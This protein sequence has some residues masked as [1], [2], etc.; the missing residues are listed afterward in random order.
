MFSKSLNFLHILWEELY[1]MQKFEKIEEDD[2]DDEKVWK[3]GQDERK[4]HP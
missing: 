4:T 3:F 1:N 2:E